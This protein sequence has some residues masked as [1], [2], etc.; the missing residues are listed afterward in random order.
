MSILIPICSAQA[1]SA[2]LRDALRHM[3]D[4]TEPDPYTPALLRGAIEDGSLGAVV[5]L[6]A[7]VSDSLRWLNLAALHS[8]QTSGALRAAGWSLEAR[9]AVAAVRDPLRAAVAHTYTAS[10]ILDD[11]HRRCGREF[12]R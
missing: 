5:S 4:L 9:R 12:V 10:M 6:I 2:Q 1:A 11:A 3:P 8:T 7:H